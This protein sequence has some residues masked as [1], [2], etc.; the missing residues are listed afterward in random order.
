MKKIGKK[1]LWVLANIEEIIATSALAIMLISI[2]TNVVLRYF[3]R[4]PTA[5]ADELAVIANGEIKAYGPKDE[6]LPELLKGSGGC[7]FTAPKNEK[8]AN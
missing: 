1:I 4:N 8:E 3:F 6:I 2:F 7:R 5:W